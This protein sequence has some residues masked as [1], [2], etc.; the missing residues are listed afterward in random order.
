M[1]QALGL[2]VV[3][4]VAVCAYAVIST[5]AAEQAARQT[6]ERLAKE[7]DQLGQLAARIAAQGKSQAL[8]GELARMENEVKARQSTLR[9]LATGEMGNTTGFSP[10]LAAFGRQALS[11]VWLRTLVVGE[12]G[13]ELFVQ[14]RALRAE[15]VPAYLRGLGRAEM[16]G[17]GVEHLVEPI[18]HL[19]PR[20]AK[21]IERA[22][23]DQAFQGA[24]AHAAQVDPLA[25][26]AQGF[27]RAAGPARLENDFDRPGA[28]VLGAVRPGPGH[29]P[30]HGDDHA[31]RLLAAAAHGAEQEHEQEVQG[32]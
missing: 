19:G 12:S 29:G 14:A 28:D 25:E 24:L 6:A 4:V 27:K 2:I 11:G 5:R 21:R 30:V 8:E 3:G 13:E 23:L 16:R 26:I 15:L 32:L 17:A 22:H 7:R 1:A 18:E 10:F 31:L 9:A 20:M